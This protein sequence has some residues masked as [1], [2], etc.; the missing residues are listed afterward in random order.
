[1][2]HLKFFSFLLLFSG[3]MH[4]QTIPVD[5]RSGKVSEAECALT[6]YPLDTAAAALV[7]FED[8]ALKIDFDVTEGVPLMN[9]FH[10]ERVKIL[11]EEEKDRCDF[12][13]YVSRDPEDL[14]SLTNIS[15]VTYNLENGK[16]V[17][18]KLPRSN[19]FRTR[20][21]DHLD[22][23]TFAAPN[24]K[25]GSVIEVQFNRSTARFRDIGDFYFQRDIPVN[26]CVY[27]LKLPRW[28]QFK[29]LTRGEASYS[30]K[31]TSE[32]G[33]Q[34]G[35]LFPGNTLDVTEY[36]AV[37]LR[38][39]NREPGLYCPRQYRSSMSVVV[40]G[41]RFPS[42]Y[43]DYS[44]TWDDVDKQVLD[45]PII[46][47][48]KANCRFEKEVDQALQGKETPQDKLAAIIA[49]VRET[50]QWNDSFR[51]VP[52]EASKVLRDRSGDSADINALV[53]SAARYAGF[54]VAPVLL[55]C[56]S[57]G[58]LMNMLPD[59]DAFD[60]MILRFELSDGTAL[61]VDAADPDG[62]FNLLRDNDLVTQARV[63]PIKGP[64]YWVDL[65]NLS[66]NITQ[67]TVSAELTPD[68]VMKGTAKAAYGGIPSYEFKEAVRRLDSEEKVLELLEKETSAEVEDFVSE[69]LEEYS[70][71]SSMQYSF[72]RNCDVTG[73]TV[74]VNP[75]MEHF[76]SETLFRAEERKLPVD[77]PY[78]EQ[79]VYTFRLVLPEGY[80]VEQ[81]PE[82]RRIA[83]ALPS[84][85]VLMAA[86]QGNAVTLSYRFDLGTLLCTPQDYQDAR[87]YWTALLALGEQ[88]IVVK[89]N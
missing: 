51:L 89:K 5:S 2:K 33:T 84:S 38:A 79:V 62:W 16:V 27:T 52:A 74:Y 28:L 14:E 17:A 25:V 59:T 19:I 85:A 44:T 40:S 64:G 45:S 69:G 13:F 30:I 77:F 50:V 86:E 70:D 73:E 43:R 8:H 88:M 71:H 56:R 81:L 49:L 46:G 83:S 20:E 75:F 78:Q 1:M 23:V 65:S 24:V 12:E 15:V 47:Q 42:L 31:E 4:A 87:A 9:I 60:K 11:K 35:D 7:L 63:V 54:D 22:K 41:L 39:L 76:H 66:R 6:T 57:N 10:R 34:L 67:Y 55:R 21:N 53:A 32:G 29:T 82:R 80:T 58:L 18:S 3:V 61:Y 26:K 68:G 37:D 72:E 48:I 36:T